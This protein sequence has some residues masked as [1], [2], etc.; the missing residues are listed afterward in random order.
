MWRTSP[1]GRW[2]PLAFVIGAFCGAACSALVL[3]L[4]SGLLEPFGPT[5]RGVLLVGLGLAAVARD[6]GLLPVELP[7]SARQIP[8]EVLA[9]G[10][11]L[12]AFRFAF[13]LGTGVRTFLTGSAPYVLAA[14]I[15]LL[16]PD[17]GTVMCAS[18]GLAIG[19]TLPVIQALGECSSAWDSTLARSRTTVRRTTVILTVVSLTSLVPGPT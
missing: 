19:R 12:G 1:V 7:Q 6:F 18:A 15:L 16:G 3:W 2:S 10:P 5:L 11:L 9:L 8:R 17:V 13:E 4:L 14:A